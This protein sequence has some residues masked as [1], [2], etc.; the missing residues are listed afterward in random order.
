LKGRKFN[1]G[2]TKK[3]NLLLTERDL[4]ILKLISVYGVLSKK[5]LN[6]Y[7]CKLY[8]DNEVAIKKRLERWCTAKVIV[9]KVYGPR[10]QLSYHLGPKGREI[11]EETELITKG[12]TLSN[13]VIPRNID[14]F[15]G[16]RDLMVKIHVDVETLG[17]SVQSYSPYEL[18][19]KKDP[20]LGVIIRPD[21]IIKINKWQ[22]NIEFDTGSESTAIILDKAARYAEWAKYKPNEYH[23][24]LFTVIDNAD[25]TFT[26]MYD[27]YG[28]ERRQRVLNLKKAIMLARAHLYPNLRFTV[29]QISRMPQIV[30]KLAIETCATEVSPFK[31]EMS[32]CQLLLDHNRAF[33][34]TIERDLNPQDI[35]LYDVDPVLYGD[36]HV[37]IKQNN[38]SHTK[39][40][41]ITYLREG[42]V[43]GLDRLEYLNLLKEQGRFKMNVDYL[44]GVYPTGTEWKSDSVGKQQNVLFTSME[45]LCH[46]EKW[47][48]Y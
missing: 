32:S 33:D 42:D 27:D 8:G 43:K 39:V 2:N 41:I 31:N 20:N 26:Y 17:L 40:M 24:I 23:H 29:A 9:R 19:F 15:F 30:R 28:V 13:N 45:H 44:V 7:S 36:V 46:L 1:L 5:E 35:Y 47:P 12:K 14:H 37:L 4:A 48:F 38:D 34:Y 18:D 16:L 3:R 22:F 21:W 25:T 11:L 6:Y 10:K